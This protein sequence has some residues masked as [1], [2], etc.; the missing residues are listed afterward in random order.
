MCVAREVYFFPASLFG[1]LRSVCSIVFA[2]YPSV[3]FSVSFEHRLRTLSRRL[4]KGCL[5][6]SLY[7]FGCPRNA[8]Q[9]LAVA[10][11]SLRLM[12]GSI[13]RGAALNVVRNRGWVCGSE[14]QLTSTSRY[15]NPNHDSHT[16][17]P[18]LRP[19]SSMSSESSVP[20]RLLSVTSQPVDRLFSRSNETSR[21]MSPCNRIAVP[22]PSRNVP[23][24]SWTSPPHSRT[25]WQGGIRERSKLMP[26][27]FVKNTV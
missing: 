3:L 23:S 16:P 4:H 6:I 11:T 7:V 8:G 2:M 17:L 20:V 25:H 5:N 27:P 26:S 12:A 14:G 19:P 24:T 9:F 22:S 10:N 15:L 18:S 1:Y 21:R 13:P